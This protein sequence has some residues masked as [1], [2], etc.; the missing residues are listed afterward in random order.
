MRRREF[1]AGLGSAVAWP[2]AAHAQPAIGFL[3]R[4]SL[5]GYAPV[6]AASTLQIDRIDIIE[7][8]TYTLD[9]TIEGRNA[10]GINQATATNINHAAAT[11]TVSAQIGTTFGFRY[12]VIGKPEDV[13]VDL[14]RIVVFPPSGLRPSASSKPMSQD[15]ATLQTKIGQTSYIF[16]TFEDNFELVPGTWTI[17][18]WYG[19]RKLATQSFTVVKPNSKPDS[20]PSPT[21]DRGDCEG[22]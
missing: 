4:A 1:I 8:G 9:R 20:K 10:R 22:L 12:K 13:P 17:E 15:E 14:R 7:Y 5:G 6:L 18:M 16:Y 19:N 3:Y 2:L 21:C 11:R